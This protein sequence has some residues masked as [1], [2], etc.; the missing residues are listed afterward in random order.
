[1]TRIAGS[2]FGVLLLVS[3][4]AGSPSSPYAGQQSRDVKALSTEEVESLLAGKGMGFAK[5]AE[6]NG[7]PGPAHVLELAP[8]LRLTDEQRRQTEAL[9]A[10]MQE[11]AKS[12]GRAL[13]DEERRLDAS[14]RTKTVTSENLAGSL[15]RIGEL[16]A[17]VRAAHLEAHLAQARILTDEQSARYASL[18]GYGEG[19]HQH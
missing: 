10:S 18:R 6:L 4:C 14:F 16:Q 12:A 5:A 8:E 9:F 2:A 7:F 15:S 17:R 3:A 19:S 13:V 11:A 1:M